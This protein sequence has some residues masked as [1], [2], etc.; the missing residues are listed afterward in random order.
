MYVFITKANS[1]QV[2]GKN[3]TPE[4]PAFYDRSSNILIKSGYLPSE[5]LCA[6]LTE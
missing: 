3:F 1:V 2:S 5:N 4:E 6:G